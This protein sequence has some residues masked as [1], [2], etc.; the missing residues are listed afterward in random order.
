MH[1]C[2]CVCIFL[3]PKILSLEP[4]TFNSCR[5][6]EDLDDD[7]SPKRN[8]DHFDEILLRP[9]PHG[10]DDNSQ[11]THEVLQS[12]RQIYHDK[13]RPLEEHFHYADLQRHVMS[14]KVLQTKINYKLCKL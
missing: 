7:D 4:T 5:V 9:D 6:S 3:L 11:S 1:M 2:T 14:G 12:L 10:Y 8:R 13:I